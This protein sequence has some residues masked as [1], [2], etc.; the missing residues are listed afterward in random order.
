MGPRHR[1]DDHMTG[2]HHVFSELDNGVTGTVKFGD[3][4]VV[5]IEGKG[6][7]LFTLR[8]GEHRRLGGVYFIPRLTTNIVSLEQMDENG[9]KVIIEEGIES[10]LEGVNRQI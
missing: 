4:S 7:V 9:F 2:S 1:R 3:G 5:N 8:S 10:C 6:T